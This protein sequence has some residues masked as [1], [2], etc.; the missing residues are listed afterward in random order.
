[1]GDEKKRVM[2]ITGGSRGIGRCIGLRFAGPGTKIFFNHYDP[3]DEAANETIKLV[4]KEGG[5][6]VGH[7]VNVA[8]PSEVDDFFK[9][10]IDEAGRVDVLI[11]N[12]GITMDAILVRMTEVA[13]DRVIDINLKGAFLC[14]QAAAKVMMKQRSGCIINI[15]S[16]VGAMGNAGQANYVASKAGLIGLTKTAAKELA[17]RGVRVN[18][19][20]PGF[21]DTEMTAKLSEKVKEAMLEQIPFKAMGQPEDVAGAAVFLASEDASYITGQVI[22]V[23]GGMYM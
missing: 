5:T 13:W 19:I 12:A 17:S 7:K 11:N 4:E 8:S 3:D 23:N 16:V 21:I 9:K 20:A 2:V 18:A 6:A 22:H 1:M 10:V 15:A 14:T